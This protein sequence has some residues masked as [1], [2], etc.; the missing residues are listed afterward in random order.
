MHALPVVVLAMVMAP[1]SGQAVEPVDLVDPLINSDHARIFQTKS[2]S[3]PFGMVQLAPDTEV[4][5]GFWGGYSYGTTNIKGFSHVRDW[6]IAGL[7]VMPT[8]DGV[9]PSGPNAWNS[10]F[11]HE[12]EVAQAGY[13]KVVL[14]RYDIG[15]ELTSTMRVAMHK[16]TFAKA[17]TADIMFDMITMMKG[18]TRLI[19]GLRR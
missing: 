10:D 17:G 4:G 9:E 8:M 19:A 18:R 5:T 2:V 12:R 14:D 16:W 7:S 13:H 1:M 15:V 11:S 3:R 6:R